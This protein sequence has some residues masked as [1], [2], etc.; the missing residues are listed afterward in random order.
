MNGNMAVEIPFTVDYR[1]TI[2][3]I[4][5]DKGYSLIDLTPSIDIRYHEPIG[6]DS[7]YS[8]ETKKFVNLGELEGFTVV[9][10]IELNLTGYERMMYDEEI[11]LLELLKEGVIL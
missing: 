7:K 11:M 1:K 6:I 9:S 8:H 5:T 3:E 4:I 10:N 2:K